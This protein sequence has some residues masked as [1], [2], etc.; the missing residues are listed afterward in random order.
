MVRTAMALRAIRGFGNPRSKRKRGFVNEP[1][2]QEAST[3]ADVDQKRLL[4]ANIAANVDQKH[5][6]ETNTATDVDQKHLLGSNTAVDVD[7]KHLPEANT[8]VVVDQKY[9]LETSTAADVHHKHLL[10]ANTAADIDQKHLLGA[11]TAADIDQMDFFAHHASVRENYVV[12]PVSPSFN[13]P[14]TEQKAP[15]STQDNLTLYGPKLPGSSVRGRRER[16][17][18]VRLARRALFHDSSHPKRCPGTE[19]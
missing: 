10:G 1:D 7:Q 5:L 9:L 16:V 11:N 17:I 8:A 3:A 12:N 6:L 19:S 14:V 18:D 4:E 2:S 13:A 15:I